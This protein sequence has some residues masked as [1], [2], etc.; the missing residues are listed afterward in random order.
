MTGF[1]ILLA[2]FMLVRYWEHAKKATATVGKVAGS[3]LQGVSGRA[4]IL[5]I[6]LLLATFA[7]LWWL[8]T[9]PFTFSELAEKTWERLV[10][11]VVITAAVTVFLSCYPFAKERLWIAGLWWVPG[12][13]LGALLVTHWA[14]AP[15]PEPCPDAVSFETRT[16]V[17]TSNKTH[18]KGSAR[19]R[20]AIGMH[21][22]YSPSEG[23]DVNRHVTS[24]G[25]Y[26][27][28]QAT[29]ADVVLRYRF[30]RSCPSSTF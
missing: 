2:L 9:N 28:F 5:W 24:G 15:K 4:W 23:V 17:L 12:V 20:A 29:R 8:Y 14:N 16:H 13:V 11:F 21:L 27:T 7:A 26:W 22:C 25:T 1:I 19:D 6:F 10:F 30:M 3:G 18:I